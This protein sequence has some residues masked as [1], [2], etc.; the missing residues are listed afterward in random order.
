MRKNIITVSLVV[1]SII[2]PTISQCQK[3]MN[4][5]AYLEG[6]VYSTS[7]E[8]TTPQKYVMI[9]DYHDYDIYGNFR[10]KSRVSGE[11][12][13]MEDGMKKW[14][15]IRITN[16][17]DLKGSYPEGERI[18]YME[19]FS[20]DPSADILSDSFFESVPQANPHMKNLVWDMTGFEVFAWYKWDS[21]QLNTTYS[22]KEINSKIDIPGLGT[23]ENKDIRV[24]WTGITEV[25]NK[26]CRIIKFNVMNNPIELNFQNFTMKGRS[27]Y[28]GNIYVSVSDKQIE[29]A[30]LDED[31]LFDIKKNGQETGTI[32]N[33]VRYITL[34]KSFK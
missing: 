16:S 30:E 11:C 26:I 27:H 33:T 20:Y 17:L 25:N 4:F 24:T 34:H 23:F 31:V 12:I 3:A 10:K 9:T 13:L 28:W 18:S 2:L 5:E 1:I 32:A 29:Y 19:N 7:L 15:N 14:N 22:A 21:L 8:E 6:L